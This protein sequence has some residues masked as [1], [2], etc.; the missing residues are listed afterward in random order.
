M[1]AVY[2]YPQF[3]ERAGTERILADKMNY[4]A[5]HEDY[6]VFFV[7]YEQ[8]ARPL[9]FPLSSKIRYIDLDIK[10]HSCYRFNLFVRLFKWWQL[11]KQ[12]QIRYNEIITE[13]NP[14]IVITT[15]SYSRPVQMV[16][17]CP[18]MSKRI[19]ESHIDR[20]YIMSNNPLCRRNIK[21]WL[22]GVRDMYVLTKN[23]RK[24]DL[25]VA[26]NRS[27]AIDWS[28]YL[29]TIV[30]SNMV[31]MN[32]TNSLARLENR[33][34]IFVGRY[35]L[36]KG[37]LDLL[38]IWKIVHSRFPDWQLNLYGEGEMRDELITQSEQL[39]ANI[40]INAPSS[41]IFE[42]YLDSS[43]LVVTSLYEPFGLIMPEAM[44][45]GLPVVAYN[46][47]EGPGQIITDGVDGFLVPCR[48]EMIF[49]E[50][51]CL[52]M[53]SYEL[54]R[55]MGGAAVISSQRFSGSVIMPIWVDLF[56]QLLK[57]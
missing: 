50:K 9:A 1:K 7:T 17:K 48:N 23:A 57:E 53:D 52:L 24:F 33:R 30:I 6:E 14:D 19:L 27:D 22:F 31:H 36:Q 44:S 15:T 32:S 55:K 46:C 12:L 5:D 4:L 13:L 29:K 39:N 21:D 35:T 26:L 10:Y 43:I 20:R 45:C 38:R 16:A 8:C 42:C 54:R 37:I 28:K 47:P 11:D 25:L 18:I 41:N 56:R 40:N 2:I 34:V 49:V 51:L 3:V